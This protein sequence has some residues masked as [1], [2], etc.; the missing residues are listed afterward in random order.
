MDT[1]FKVRVWVSTTFI[2]IS[3]LVFESCIFNNNHYS[4]SDHQGNI[5]IYIDSDTSG[6]TRIQT[7]QSY[8][9]YNSFEVVSKGLKDTLI[10]SVREFDL[11]RILNPTIDLDSVIVRAGDTL[12]LDIL[13]EGYARKHYRDGKLMDATEIPNPFEI[14]N[15]KG[16]MIDSLQNLFLYVDYSRPFDF[17]FE[18]TRYTE[19]PIIPISENIESKP[20]VLEDYVNHIFEDFKMRYA[21]R[22]P[23][24]PI[25]LH[26]L[27]AEIQLSKIMGS[28][29]FLYRQKPYDFLKKAMFSDVFLSYRESDSI[30]LSFINR[31]IHML[32][33]G[34]S[35]NEDIHRLLLQVYNNASDYWSEEVLVEYARYYI[36]SKQV[37]SAFD[38]ELLT[39]RIESF[40]DKYPNSKWVK[41]LRDFHK[42][43]SINQ[44]F[45][46]TSKDSLFHRSGKATTY[47]DLLNE[48]AG[49]YIFVDFWA[50]WCAPC[51]KALP[52]I[53]ILKKELDNPNIL[54]LFISIDENM[55][56]WRKAEERFFPHGYTNSFISPGFNGSTLQTELNVVSIPRYVLFDNNGKLLLNQSGISVEEISNTLRNL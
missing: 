31:Q 10:L 7:T 53:I 15:F 45:L 36:M 56:G 1:V 8:W 47:P 51:I 25:A 5:L 4:S 39:K 14:A 28:I 22:P 32:E 11:V 20:T 26:Q 33:Q 12:Y 40:A 46:F 54:F 50:S 44:D 37:K 55:D 24:V 41:V 6:T 9:N 52:H 21:D 42:T 23:G 3:L 48:N 18:D 16:T 30:S 17:A 34:L 27:Y 35:K 19:Y 49:K 43:Q 29:M 38:E 13:R 2:L